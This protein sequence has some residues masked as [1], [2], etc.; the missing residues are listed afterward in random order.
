MIEPRRL[1]VLGSTGS[2]G[3]NTLSVV[4]HLNRSSATKIDVVGLAAGRSTERLIEQARW[5]KVRHIA[6]AD[7]SAKA[8]IEAAL[9]EAVVFA[10]EDAAQQ[11]VETVDATDVA[12]AIV[13]AAGLGATVM[14]N[15]P[16][17]TY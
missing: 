9:S 10:G 13:G 11:L 7:A 17:V 16:S 12:S 3:V 2:I 1:I 15:S 4:D 5:H 8:Q 14:I 6:I